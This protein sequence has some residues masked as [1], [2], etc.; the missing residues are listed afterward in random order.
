MASSHIKAAASPHEVLLVEDS[1]TGQTG[2]SARS[3][4]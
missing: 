1:S 3:F 2:Q 4:D